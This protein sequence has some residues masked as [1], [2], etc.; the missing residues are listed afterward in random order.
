MYETHARLAIEVGDLP[1][2]NQVGSCLFNNNLGRVLFY[3]IDSLLFLI[4]FDL[5]RLFEL[6]LLK[7]I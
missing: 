3:E 1:E 2:Y 5:L 4:F 7:P 6:G